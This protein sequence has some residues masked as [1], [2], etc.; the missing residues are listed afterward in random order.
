VGIVTD[1]KGARSIAD[2]AGAALI[3]IA[4]D[5]RLSPD[6]TIRL[7]LLI[8]EW[9]PSLWTH[10]PRI[11]QVATG[12]MLL[13]LWGTSWD[14]E[15]AWIGTSGLRLDLRR[16]DRGGGFTMLITFADGLFRI[17]EMGNRG[18]PLAEVRNGM[19]EAFEKAHQRYLESLNVPA[20]AKADALPRA[21]PP[22]VD[23]R[24]V[25]IFSLLKT[26]RALWAKFR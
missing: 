26:W 20:N 6:H 16:Y 25:E 15:T 3:S 23:R 21:S 1:D 18:R 7:D 9:S 12:R 8:S 4:S 24:Q 5:T 10:A 14:A 19:D 17:V 13:D 2:S 11:T 22:H